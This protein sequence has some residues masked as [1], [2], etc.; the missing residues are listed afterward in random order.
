MDSNHKIFRRQPYLWFAICVA[1]LV[2]LGNLLWIKL[3]TRPQPVIDEYVHK[4]FVLAD[5][6]ANR[7][8][9]S[10]P[11]SIYRA[12]IGPRPPGYQ[13]LAAPF[14]IFIDRSPDAMLI[15]NAIFL[16][17]LAFATFKIGELV[18]DSRVGFLSATIVVTFPLIINLAKITR[19]HAILPATISLFI[20]ALF[21]FA[22]KPTTSGMWWLI[23][24]LLLVF[25][26]HPA[27]LHLAI[28]PMATV[29]IY[30]LLPRKHEGTPQC[31]TTFHY[32]LRSSL[33]KPFVIY[34]M[35]P[36]LGLFMLIVAAWLTLKWDQYLGMA[37]VIRQHTPLQKDYF[38]YL[39]TLHLATSSWLASIFFLSFSL[40]IAQEV[41]ARRKAVSRLAPILIIVLMFLGI[42][43]ASVAQVWDNFGGALP[44]VAVISAM[45]ISCFINMVSENAKRGLFKT[46]APKIVLALLFSAIATNY[47]VVN[48]GIPANGTFLKL[49]GANQDC[50]ERRFLFFCTDPPKDGD[51]QITSIVTSIRENGNCLETSC[52][53][54]LVSHRQQYF[55]DEAFNYMVTQLFPGTKIEVDRLSCDQKKRHEWLRADFVVYLIGPESSVVSPY[56][57]H[58]D[59]RYIVEFLQGKPAI[60]NDF[61]VRY[62]GKLPNGEVAILMQR[63]GVLSL[64]RIR[65]ILLTTGTDNGNC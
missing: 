9:L 43:S 6:L 16:V 18:Q 5:D 7:K 15:V 1:T 60:Q 55:S 34:G 28:G 35:L 59:E 53:V 65:E 23:G 32:W 26:I 61:I 42:I 39:R 25:S 63:R 51:W 47:S 3:D 11:L 38:Y 27:G 62:S 20:W 8:V 56:A 37:E 44:I 10:I 13:V 58:L 46:T 31:Q 21:A 33:R 29:L 19:P 48:W 4:T 41:I 36:G 30:V 2:S 52:K 45:G 17:L 22:R 64:D 40:V 54:T 57:E 14:V 12:T 50:Y 24:A 49:I